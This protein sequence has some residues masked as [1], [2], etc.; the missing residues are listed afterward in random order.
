MTDVTKLSQKVMNIYK[1]HSRLLKLCP[2]TTN[3]CH[4][5][6]H[7]FLIF[8]EKIVQ[9]WSHHGGTIGKLLQGLKEMERKDVIEIIEEKILEDCRGVSATN[10]AY[11]DAVTTTNILTLKVIFQTFQNSAHNS[12]R[13]SKHLSSI[14]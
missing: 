10:E 11:L 12:G 14:L 6:S 7:G 5:C 2:F 4:F 13:W 3:C 9:K 8:K 1:H